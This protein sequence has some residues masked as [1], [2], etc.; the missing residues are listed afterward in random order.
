MVRRSAEPADADHEAVCIS[1]D[2]RRRQQ[3]STQVSRNV[4]FPIQII[5]FHI[6]ASLERIG[7]Q[8]EAI[9]INKKNDHG[10]V[11]IRPKNTIPNP[12]LVKSTLES[13]RSDGWELCHTQIT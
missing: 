12:Q 3:T 10:I 11:L 13:T 7:I 5:S 8:T 1:C 4:L 2:L 6:E 9:V